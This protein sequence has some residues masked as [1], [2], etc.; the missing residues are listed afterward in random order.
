M[1]SRRCRQPVGQVR[2]AS[3][4][5]FPRRNLQRIVAVAATPN[6][7]GVN[8]WIGE[9]KG[10]GHRQH[11]GKEKA[12]G[13]QLVEPVGQL[14]CR[15]PVREHDDRPG[16]TTIGSHADEPKK[17]LDHGGRRESQGEP[18]TK[19]GQSV[20]VAHGQRVHRRG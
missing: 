15:S 18:Q 1:P 14:R 17:L 12:H 4:R 13:C 2:I 8:E 16:N 20:G 5:K 19:C 11:R 7:T 3:R 9:K 10:D 6:E